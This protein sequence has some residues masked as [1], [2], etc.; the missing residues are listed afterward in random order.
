MKPKYFDLKLLFTALALFIIGLISI[1][2]VTSHGTNVSA[3]SLMTKQLLWMAV[4][5]LAFILS[6][7][8]GYQRFLD[9]SFLFYIIILVLLVML[10]ML[11]PIIAGAQR[12]L[13][14]M[15]LNF[16]PS[17]FA[18][19]SL[20]LVLSR[21]FIRS[22]ES[23][24]KLKTVLTAVVLLVIYAFLIF[25]QPDLGSALILVPI[26]IAM[27]IS[28]RIRM[29]HIMGLII[30]GTTLIPLFWFILK[31]YQKERLLV[32]LDPNSDPLGAGY[33]IIQSKIAIGSGGLLGKGWLKG[34]QSQFNFLP[35]GHTDFIF[36][37]FCEE[38]G[39]IG[40]I[41]V[42]FLYY[43]LLKRILDT[44]L[45]TNN[46]SAKLLCVGI[47]TF[48]FSHVFIN[49]GMVTGIMPVVGLPLPFLSYGGSNLMVVMIALGIVASIRKDA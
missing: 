9:F 42:I 8:F 10:I 30:T 27:T 2:S 5:V 32:F 31:D 49:I 21:L 7:A 37:V 38:W 26:F 29:K 4:S 35:E 16:Q 34:S 14:I 33:T 17:E 24:Y 44:A 48:I 13:K 46:F 22:R 25:Q 3:D 6:S 11:G 28:A 1:Y 23:L 12:W 36:A 40:A 19:L 18:K 15:G 47:A 45:L 43:L 39:F 20:I 41:V